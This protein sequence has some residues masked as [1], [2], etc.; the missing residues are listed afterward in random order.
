MSSLARAL[1]AR[2]FDRPHGDNRENPKGPTG[3]T[4]LHEPEPGRPVAA[5]IVFVHGLNGGSRS[6]WSDRGDPK[7]FWPGQWLPDDEAFADARIHSFGYLSGVSRRSVLDVQDF[8]NALM[9]AVAHSPAM[10]RVVE[11]QV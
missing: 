10:G 4:T 1:L 9:V 7:L 3:L 11:K 8:A 2:A 5:D 6:T